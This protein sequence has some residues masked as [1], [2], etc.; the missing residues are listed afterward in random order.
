MR[1]TFIHSAF[2]ILLLLGICIFQGG[3][4]YIGQVL[5]WVFPITLAAL[6]LLRH[7]WA[8][9]GVPW[10]IDTLLWVIFLGTAG[11][12]SLLSPN[13]AYTV[14]S[15]FTYLSFFLTYTVAKIYFRN[16]NAALHWF[17]AFIVLGVVSG[18]IVVL[19][20]LGVYSYHTNL[21]DVFYPHYGHSPITY[22]ITGAGLLLLTYIH[23][24][25]KHRHVGSLLGILLFFLLILSTFSR[26]SL[27]IFGGAVILLYGVHY[28]HKT[29]LVRVLSVIFFILC[30]STLVFRGYT[31]GKPLSQSGNFAFV[32][33][34]LMKKAPFGSR[35]LYWKQTARFIRLSPLFGKGLDTFRLY[36][37]RLT[38][39]PTQ[40][41]WY[42]HTIAVVFGE[43]GLFGGFVYVL[44]FVWLVVAVYKQVSAHNVTHELV[45][46]MVL[47]VAMGIFALLDSSWSF[48]VFQLIF[49]ITAA[50]IISK[51]QSQKNLSGFILLAPF[52]VLFVYICVY[53]TTGVLMIMGYASLARKLPSSMIQPYLQG[54]KQS[55]EA[56]DAQGEQASLQVLASLAADDSDTAMQLM[57]VYDGAHRITDQIY[58]IRKLIDLKPLDT[59]DS[60]GYV[61]DLY[62]NQ[63]DMQK[64]KEV[65]DLFI[66][67]FSTL[68]DYGAF[69]RSISQ[70][71][72]QASELYY[73]QL[74]DIST[75]LELMR[76]AIQVNYYHELS[77]IQLSLVQIIVGD[78]VFD[79]SLRR[80][81]FTQFERIIMTTPGMEQSRHHDEIGRIL[82]QYALSIQ[83]T[84]P[85]ET[86]RILEESIRFN[87]KWF[88]NYHDVIITLKDMGNLQKALM[89][90]QSCVDNVQGDA[91]CSQ[92]VREL[93]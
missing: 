70:Q 61:R 35:P 57:S 36:S 53:L 32:R 10:G 15:L 3:T 66:S 58:W 11:I 90:A 12:S 31:L 8:V 24:K 52:C 63:N 92:Q 80:S 82:R 1:Q 81:Y 78:R 67:R 34:I 5:V 4:S 51:Q 41:S 28:W 56:K 7:K 27:I 59:P 72:F 44:L 16:R 55:V 73:A 76:R 43:V 18:S 48:P 2:F 89:Y 38:N 6:L 19:Y 49:W 26:L 74:H 77:L 50:Y 46:A 68:T 93:Q 33:T 60:Y 29:K 40:W 47:V 91:W 64:A 25:R 9:L 17:T 20:L 79:E 88:D 30:V 85:A 21:S 62:L 83:Q 75:S 69:G 13:K 87:K 39:A 54:V 22:I 86:L 14:P 45:S 42:P 84:N 71:F 37:P 23:Q 65:T